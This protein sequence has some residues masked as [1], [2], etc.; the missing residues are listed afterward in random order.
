MLLVERN[1]AKPVRI[2]EATSTQLPDGVLLRLIYPVCNIGELNANKRMYERELW[3]LVLENQDLQEKLSNRNLYGQAEHPKETASDLQLT[4][5]IIHEMWIG[6]DSRVYQTFDVLD[7]PCGRIIECLVRAGSKVGVST[8]A[9]GDLEEAVGE[10]GQK[11][12][13]VV[14]KSYR[15]VTT[16]FTADPSTFGAM[17]VDVKKNIITAARTAAESKT[18]K[19][20]EVRFARGILESLECDHKNTCQ[21][22]GAC[23]CHKGE[24]P[25]MTK[26]TVAEA[27]KSGKLTEGKTVAVVFGAGTGVEKRVDVSK[28]VKI[29]ENTM[30]IQVNGSDPNSKSLTVDGSYVVELLPDGG[31][32]VFASDSNPNSAGPNSAKGF[33]DELANALAAEEGGPEAGAEAAPAGEVEAGKTA[34]EIPGEEK[35]EEEG[36]PESKKTNEAKLTEKVEGLKSIF[37]ASFESKSGSV[38]TDYQ[39][40]AIFEGE[41]K[42]LVLT[43]SNAESE[44]M[45][46]GENIAKLTKVPFEGRKEYTIESKVNEELTGDQD[47]LQKLALHVMREKQVDWAGMIPIVAR[48]IDKTPEE[49]EELLNQAIEAGRAPDREGGR[50]EFQPNDSY[51][52]SKEEG[53]YTESKV[54]PLDALIDLRIKEACTRAERDTLLEG[55][56]VQVRVLAS[57]LK[58]SAEEIAG[59]RALVEKKTSALKESTK[60]NKDVEKLNESIKTQHTA[61]QQELVETANKSRSDGR[62]EVLKDYF[63]SRLSACRLE[64]DDNTQALLERCKGLDD[65]D[66][67]I[68]SLVQVAQRG[69][70]H[71]SSLKDVVV[72]ERKTDPEQD[73]IDGQIGGLMKSWSA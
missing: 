16:D 66:Q 73:K 17:A 36:L 68:E 52:K 30:S 38:P 25:D 40:C 13:R 14:P 45:S 7:T 55:R 24:G 60:P 6:E 35:K 43:H 23:K 21:N 4:S 61:H 2:L 42:P 31:I 50:P 20:S 3:D 1:F 59:L 39:V 12:H 46:A 32:N 19:M 67:L 69:A 33:E 51:V 29:H 37:V 26:S 10:D 47:R 9:E 48:L 27:I 54:P 41:P 8:R 34:E 15:Y 63:D 70:L 64:A 57:R 49:T 28:A 11:Y 58:A 53:T 72:R 5:H 22:C 18:S 65:V 71:P 44:A 62:N 56:D